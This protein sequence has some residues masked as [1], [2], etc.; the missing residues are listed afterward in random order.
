MV[1]TQQQYEDDFV[2]ID[3]KEYEKVKGQNLYEDLVNLDI[4]SEEDYKNASPE[5]KKRYDE[6]KAE[7]KDDITG[8]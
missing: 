2:V 6:L 8:K 1:M 4:I 5:K 7:T 3:K